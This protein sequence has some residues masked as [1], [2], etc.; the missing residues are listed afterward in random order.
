MLKKYYHLHYLYY[1]RTNNSLDK[2]TVGGELVLK[3]DKLGGNSYRYVFNHPLTS[4]D[5][6]DFDSMK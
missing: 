2:D 6:D 4:I 3:E 1:T 5:D